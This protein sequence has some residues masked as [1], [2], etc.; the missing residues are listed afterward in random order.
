MSILEL[1]NRVMSIPT[2]ENR[3]ISLEQALILATRDLA[4]LEEV[5]LKEKR[6]V[7]EM[8]KSIAS[9]YLLKLVN[10]YEAKLDKEVDE[11]LKAKLDYDAAVERVRYLEGKKLALVER[12]AVLQVDQK[13]YLSELAKKKQALLC[14]FHGERINELE[15]KGNTLVAKITELSEA[16]D[17]SNVLISTLDKLIILMDKAELLADYDSFNNASFFSH[18]FKYEIIDETEAYYNLLKNNLSDLKAE[19]GDVDWLHDFENIAISG[20]MR[21]FDVLFGSFLLNI[22]LH[23]QIKTQLAQLKVLKGDVNILHTDLTAQ[24]NALQNELAINMRLEEEL[25]LLCK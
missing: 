19:V 25:L 22:T 11:E 10:K 12:I 17:S 15:V 4:N 21:M 6:D 7:D 24:L 5:Y 14:G 2:L 8:K 16:L 23:T 20:S 9:K 1:R 3:L 13:T 18:S